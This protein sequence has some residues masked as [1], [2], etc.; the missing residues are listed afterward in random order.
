MRDMK[1]EDDLLATNQFFLLGRWLSYLPAWSSSPA[2]LSR[3]EYDAHSILTT[4]GD[5]VASEDL[6]EYGNRDWSGLIS[7][8]Y[9]PRWQLYF[10]SLETALKTGTE[11][12]PIDW[13][14]FGDAWN[15]SSTRF[16]ANPSGDPYTAG[17]TI[18]K[19]LGLAPESDTPVRVQ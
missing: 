11:P 17:L 1:L 12:K 9:A 10:D 7:S 8:Y 14:K 13:Y 5:R 6:H 18:A 4:W 16:A 3:I 15:R 19:A 2:D